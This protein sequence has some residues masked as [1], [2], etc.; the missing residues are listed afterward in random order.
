MKNT[1][2]DWRQFKEKISMG[3]KVGK[4]IPFLKDNACVHVEEREL[5][6]WCEIYTVLNPEDKEFNDFLLNMAIP[7]LRK[8]GMSRWYRDIL[9]DLALALSQKEKQTTDESEKDVLKG[10]EP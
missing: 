4:I 5:I 3:E 10:I 9:T 1:F 6:A 8:L 7:S 2:F